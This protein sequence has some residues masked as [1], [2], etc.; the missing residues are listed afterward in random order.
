MEHPVNIRLMLDL[1]R[2]S[3]DPGKGELTDKLHLPGHGDL[4][5]Y[6]ADDGFTKLQLHNTTTT[7]PIRLTRRFQ[8]TNAINS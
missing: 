3:D 7:P 5:A 1:T 8:L 6:A 2:E 4:S